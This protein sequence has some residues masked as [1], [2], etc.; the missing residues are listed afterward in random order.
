LLDKLDELN[1]AG[2]TIV[3]FTSDHGYNIGHHGIHTKGNG[4]WVAGGV[5]GPKRPNLWD[6]SIRVPL[7]IRWPG[8]A[9][10]GTEIGEPVSNIDTFASVLGMLGVS[11]PGG[12]KQ[13]GMDFSPLLR[14]Q[15]VEWRD[16]IFGQYDLHNGGQANMRMIRTSGWK[17]VRHHFTNQLDELYDL[18]K[19]PDE[20]TNLFNRPEHRSVREQLQA[21]LTDWQRSISDPIL[22]IDR[23]SAKNGPGR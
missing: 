19:D 16:T 4:I 11:V 13:Q 14:C 17:L 22:E 2:R 3:L 23:V 9:K 6:T 21:R 7:I 10:P 15:K 18:E 1:L 12:V 20:L 5:N 8:V